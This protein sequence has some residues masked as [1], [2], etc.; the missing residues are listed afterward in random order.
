MTSAIVVYC[1][2]FTATYMIMTLN[3]AK[4]KY[5]VHF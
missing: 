1:E 4:H 5:T 3:F 2:H